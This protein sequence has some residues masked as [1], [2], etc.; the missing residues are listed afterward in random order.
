MTASAPQSLVLTAGRSSELSSHFRA[1]ADIDAA[2]EP[3]YGRAD[4]RELVR[5]TVCRAYAPALLELSHLVS[6][7][8]L[9]GRWENLFWAPHPA[10][11][12]HFREHFRAALAKSPVSGLAL[13]E[14]GL[15]IAYPDG[16]FTISFRRMSFLS[17]LMEMMVGTLGYD[18]VDDTLKAATAHPRTASAASAAASAMARAYY[19][20]LKDHVPP[21]Q[22]QR[23]FREM[24]AWLAGRMGEEFAGRD[25]TDSLILDFWLAHAEGGGD[26]NDFRT[27]QATFR[28]FVNLLSALDQAGRIL[29]IEDARPVGVD[30]EKGEV[31]VAA[32]AR[33]DI[34][35][36]L[37][38]LEAL[39][40]EPA[41]RVK[42]LNKQEQAQLMLLFDIGP[43]AARLPASLMR[44]EVFGKAQARIT[45]GMRRKLS[46]A[47]LSALINESAGEDYAARRAALAEL[48]E[49]IGKIL[50]ASLYVLVRG[51]SLEAISLLLELADGF[52][53]GA[54]AHLLRDMP[55]KNLAE[56]F[57][58]LMN[59][60]ERAPPEISAAMQAAA[61]A[62]KSSARQGFDGDPAKDAD[63]LAAFEEGTGHVLS[64]RKGLAAY[65]SATEE[66]NWPDLFIADKRIFTA[67]FHKLYG[68]AA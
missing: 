46:G 64:V 66:I 37:N 31:D 63:I 29:E 38:P 61:R 55:G 11:A 27:F 2:G 19:E 59:D 22:S 65:L 5:I 68:D 26:G 53:A 28:A 15:A 7:A 36:R 24:T 50:S 8:S 56:K 41:S 57:L 9:C 42:F 48:L 49:G 23:K 18:V 25:I 12:C 39:S 3:K 4:I 62:F 52:D 17:A 14:G 51:G 44:C 67:E 60:P 32:G 10:R 21:A 13:A 35:E 34:P 6:A 40:E 54:H 45:Q 43:L 16:K 1:I 20:F 58:A 30:A 47:E 33:C